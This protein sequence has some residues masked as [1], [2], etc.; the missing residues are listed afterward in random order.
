M[1]YISGWLVEPIPLKN[2]KINGVGIIPY[3]GKQK[4]FQTTSQIYI[5][6]Y[7]DELL[8]SIQYILKWESVSKWVYKSL[9]IQ[10][11]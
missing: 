8:S 3:Y 4:M 5:Y 6:I 1:E 7:I 2:M 9:S 11:F 10:R